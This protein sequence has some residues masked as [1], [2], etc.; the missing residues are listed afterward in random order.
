MLRGAY[1]P[2]YRHDGCQQTSRSQGI[3]AE[4]VPAAD[5]GHGGILERLLQRALVIQFGIF[6]TIMIAQLL[7]IA[8]CCTDVHAQRGYAVFQEEGVKADSEFL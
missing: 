6:E 2:G 3:P 4:P 5:Y 7:I 8:I 1:E